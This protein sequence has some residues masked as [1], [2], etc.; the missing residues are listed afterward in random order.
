MIRLSVGFNTT[1]SWISRAIRWFTKS[2]RSHAYLHFGL[3]DIDLIFQASAV[4]FSIAPLRDRGFEYEEI[5]VTKKVDVPH[6]LQ[7]CQDWWGEPYDF[8]GLF[9]EAW[10]MLGRWLGR[11][12]DNPLASPHTLYCS[13]A[14]LY[15]LQYAWIGPSP[16]QLATD[17]RSV[18][19]G[20]L[21]TLLQEVMK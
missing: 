5:D 8:R 17:A 3:D 15:L 4:G 21:L 6:A 13:E 9:G 10:V 2:P 7:L 1:E 16:K 12:W 11:T 14:V 19:P 20:E 18:D